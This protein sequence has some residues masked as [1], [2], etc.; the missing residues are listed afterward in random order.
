MDIIGAGSES[1]QD[2]AS[3]ANVTPIAM[4]RGGMDYLNEFDEDN[5]QGL[6]DAGNL[7]LTWGDWTPPMNA[8]NVALAGNL[9]MSE[10]GDIKQRAYAMRD[11]ARDYKKIDPTI[12]DQMLAERAYITEQHIKLARATARQSDS[13]TAVVPVEGT[14]GV[15]VKA[16]DDAHTIRQKIFEKLTKG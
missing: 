13:G 14:D 10:V 8:G 4:L 12:S 9:Y 11:W 3:R 16:G 15:L 2:L 1:K 7:D 6:L 5:I